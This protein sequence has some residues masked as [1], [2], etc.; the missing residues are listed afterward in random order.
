VEHMPM[1][2]KH[3]E[4]PLSKP[5]PEFV[6]DGIQITPDKPSKPTKETKPEFEAVDISD[7]F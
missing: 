2:S 7:I 6:R 4:K 3:T 5:A 1:R